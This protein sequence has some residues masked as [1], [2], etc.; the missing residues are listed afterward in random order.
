MLRDTWATL[1]SRQWN[2]HEKENTEDRLKAFEEGEDA[3]L[4]G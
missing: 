4:R 3:H 1:N 2:G